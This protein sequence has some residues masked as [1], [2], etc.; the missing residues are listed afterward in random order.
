MKI[1]EIKFN[2]L[3]RYKLSTY[4]EAESEKEAFQKIKEDK[5][6]HEVQYGEGKVVK[7]DNFETIGVEFKEE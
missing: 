7:R 3:V 2:K 6:E 1:Y 4:I 5:Y